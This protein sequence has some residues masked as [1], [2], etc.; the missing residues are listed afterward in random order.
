[1]LLARCRDVALDPV[2]KLEEGPLLELVVL[3]LLDIVV[4]EAALD[5]LRC[6][7]Q[8]AGV[9]AVGEDLAIGIGDLPHPVESVEAKLRGRHEGHGRAHH[10]YSLRFLG[11][12]AQGSVKIGA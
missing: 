10:W 9:V 1:M 7:H 3:Q 11:D 4:G 12:L 5:A 6:I 2:A 8:A